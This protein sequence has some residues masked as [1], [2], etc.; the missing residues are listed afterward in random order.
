[1]RLYI[2]LSGEDAL[3]ENGDPITKEKAQEYFDK[4]FD[5]YKGVADF[6][7][8]QK[9]FAHRHEVVYTLIGRKRRLAGINSG[10]FKDV[11]YWERI[12][13]NA[14]I[15]GSGADIMLMCQPAIDNA[16]KLKKLGCTMRLQIH[17]EL[18]FNCPKKH[19]D[20]A[21]DI[22]KSYMEHPL[23]QELNVP[24]RVDCDFGHSYAQAK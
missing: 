14:P 2:E 15:Q 4:Y 24:L 1:M 8:N 18:V 23:K 5:A 12:S 21:I 10:N 19:V 9:K 6:I 20:E 3:D 7:K 13:V 17:D 16:V 22:I 11:G